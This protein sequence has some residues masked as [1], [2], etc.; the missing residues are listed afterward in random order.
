MPPETTRM[1]VSEFYNIDA[2]ID[3]EAIRKIYFDSAGYNTIDKYQVWLTLQHASRLLLETY[4]MVIRLRSGKVKNWKRYLESRSIKLDRL[5]RTFR[6]SFLRC[7]LSSGRPNIGLTE[8]LK[9]KGL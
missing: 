3:A 7:T 8:I 9:R 5:K 2:L 1:H 6:S 4:N